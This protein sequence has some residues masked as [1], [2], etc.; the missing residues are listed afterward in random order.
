MINGVINVYKEPDYTSHDVVARLRGITHQ[1]KIGHTGTLDPAAVG[2][3]CVCLGAATRICDMLTDETKEYEAVMLLGVTTDTQDTTGEI[4]KECPV[5]ITIG[6]DDSNAQNQITENKIREVIARYIGEIEQIPPMYSALKVNGKKLYELARAGIEV[7]RKARRITIFNIDIVDITLPRVTIRVTCSKGTYIRTLCNDIGDELGCG[8]AMEHL[9]RTRVGHFEVQ[10]A[11]TL[12]EIEEYMKRDAIDEI[13][14]APVDVFA[15][16]RTYVVTGE[17][18]IKR[19]DNGNVL[20]MD[21]VRADALNEVAPLNADDKVK[22]V[23]EDGFFYGVFS[24]D[25]QG[26]CLKPWKMFLC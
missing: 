12:D 22:V 6:G 3:L 4:I 16:L 21:D 23:R 8:A 10:S 15:D 25:E 7:E 18:G 2:V 26:R 13:V 11:H 17:A 24:Y 5:D 14:V 9:T 20:L 19:A 1:K